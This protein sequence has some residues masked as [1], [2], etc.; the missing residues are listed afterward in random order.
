MHY[1]G[2]FQIQ[3]V[4]RKRGFTYVAEKIVGWFTDLR[5]RLWEP[6]LQ[7]ESL[8]LS[9]PPPSRIFLLFLGCPLSTILSPSLISVASAG[10]HL[11][12]GS[13]QFG[14]QQLRMTC[15]QLR[16]LG[17]GSGPSIRYVM[18]IPGSIMCPG[19]WSSMVDPHWLPQKEGMDVP[20][21]GVG[22]TC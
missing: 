22:G 8:V 2:P 6:R 4:W 11:T 16:G 15:S 3:T 13:F 9:P 17:L 19:K 1:S 7:G 12:S 21:Q 18:S 5:G 10:P 20:G 14:Y